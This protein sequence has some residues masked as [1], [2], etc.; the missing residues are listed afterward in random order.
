MK[1]YGVDLAEGSQITNT[2]VAHGT[3]FPA[4]PDVGELFYRNTGVPA[5]DG[6]YVYNGTSWAVVINPALNNTVAYRHVQTVAS[7]TWTV[8]HNLG[9]VALQITTYLDDGGGTF[10][11]IIP[12]YE[13]ILNANTVEIDFS[14][15]FTGQVML[16]G[17]VI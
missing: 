6:L 14:T 8:V 1:M 3:T 10:T 12:R 5:V 4:S 11:K 13:R 7:S 9:T 17:M 2:V 15:A 16:V